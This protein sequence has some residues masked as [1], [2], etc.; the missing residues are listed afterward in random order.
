MQSHRDCNA[1]YTRTTSFTLGEELDG[2]FESKSTAAPTRSTT[3]WRAGG[4]VRDRSRAPARRVY[5]LSQAACTSAAT[6]VD[7]A[8]GL[9]RQTLT[10]STEQVIDF[11]RTY[12]FKLHFR[13]S[14]DGGKASV[15]TLLLNQV[16]YMRAGEFESRGWRGELRRRRSRM[17]ALRRTAPCAS[18]RHRPGRHRRTTRRP[19]SRR[20]PPA[21]A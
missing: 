2:S 14:T 19:P 21:A 3:A 11:R 16:E 1:R 12:G 15:K 7:T 10:T 6:V 13:K 18:R 9:D 4:L 20:D 8:L 17:R 5:D